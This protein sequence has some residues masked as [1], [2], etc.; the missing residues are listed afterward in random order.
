MT[1]KGAGR[2]NAVRGHTGPGNTVRA[3]RVREIA[4]KWIGETFIQKNQD[5][6]DS[7]I[8][9]G[10]TI[11]LWFPEGVIL[12]SQLK[13]TFFQLL[14]RMLD[15]MIRTSNLILR[16]KDPEVDDEK[17]YQTIADNGVYS[18]MT[19]EACLNGVEEDGD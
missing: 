2:A 16:G 17:A 13:I 5:Y 10:K 14:T 7:Y 15:K 9:A 1:L 11:E 12:D 4:G 6:S 18:F 8:V 19:A 3:E